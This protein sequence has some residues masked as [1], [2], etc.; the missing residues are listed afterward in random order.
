M[1]IQIKL[2]PIV[3]VD[4]R[5]LAYGY[6]GNSR[7]LIE[8]LKYLVR[9]N[10]HFEYRLYSNKPIHPVFQSFIDES[11]I[12]VAPIEQMP[13]IL[14]LNFYLPKTLVDD[15]IDLFWGTLQLL[16]IFKL[17]FP[18]V[19]NYHDLNFVSAP[20]TMSLLN[21][22]QHKILSS[23]TLE[24]AN[25]VFCLSENTK[26]DISAYKPSVA[27]KLTVIYPG[28]NKSEVSEENLGITNF[29]LTISTIEPRKNLKTLI[30]GYLEVV[31]HNS[32]FPYKLVIAGRLGWGENSLAQDLQNGIY[33]DK[34][35]VFIENPSESALSYLLHNCEFFLF[36]SKHEG[37]GLPIIEAMVE[38]RVC[39]T[40]DI[41]V[42]REIVEPGIDLI[43]DTL[44]PSSWAEK[45]LEMSQKPQSSRRRTLKSTKWN[46][47]T[48]GKLIETEITSVW[49]SYIKEKTMS[50]AF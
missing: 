7:Y 24:N 18:T 9:K 27:E 47:Q 32:S 22:L 38:G 4:A 40:S 11:G 39:I 16:P 28:A 8:A 17:P 41:P 19:V 26:N 12:V 14:W 45:I 21:Y 25:R 29:L 34:G 13:G 23:Y 50:H 10:S 3:G 5:P 46:W 31:K 49:N 2:K 1:S 35:I 44:N 30:D 42:F 15:K 33:L 48:T 36:P 37:F 20:K 43:A 6:T